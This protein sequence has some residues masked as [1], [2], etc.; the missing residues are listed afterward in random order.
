MNNF[1]YGSGSFGKWFIDEFGLPAYH[2]TCDQISDER[3]VSPCNPLWRNNTDHLHQIGNFRLNAVASNYGY[4]QVR[5]DEGCVKFLNDYRPEDN[6]LA[7]GIGYLTDENETL[8]TAYSKDNRELVRIFGSGYFK[9]RITNSKYCVEQVIYAPYGDDPLLISQVTVKNKSGNE[10]YVNWEEL[11]DCS[12]YQISFRSVLESILLQDIHKIPEIRRN[13]SKK[14][15]HNFEIIGNGKGI[16][17]TSKFSG[18]TDDEK[19]AWS[20]TKAVIEGISSGLFGGKIHSDVPGVSFYDYTPPSVFLVAL[21][22]PAAKL[23]IPDGTYMNLKRN[24]VLKPGE[25]KTIFNSFGYIPHGSNLSDIMELIDG[26]FSNPQSV[27]EE[28]CNSWKGRA[29]ILSVPDEPWVERELRWSNYYLKSNTTYDSFFGE[30]V[31]SQGSGYQYLMGIQAAPRDQ[32]QHCLPLIFTE[33]WLVKENI[34]YILKESLPDGELP[35][36]ITGNGMITP[37]PIKSSDFQLWII[38][39]VCEYV[40]A[41]RDISFLDEELKTYPVGGKEREPEKILSVLERMYKYLFRG[42]GY[43]RH[44]LLRLLKGDWNDLI[45]QGFVSSDQHD[46]VEAEAE[47]LLNS[48]M[49]SYV[50]RL[51]SGLYKYLG[52]VDKADQLAE[53]AADLRHA[54]QEQWNGKWFRRAW[55]PG[56][57]GWVGDNELWLEPQPWAVIGGCAESGHPAVLTENIDKLLREPSPIG[58]MLIDKPVAPE[59]GEMT[60]GGVWPSINGTLIWA[61]A[62][63]NPQKGWDEWKKNLLSTHAEIYPDIWYGIWSGPDYYNSVLARYPGHTFFDKSILDGGP[64]APALPNWTDFPVMCMHPHAWTIYSVLK[65]LGTEFT[66]SGIEFRPA[67]PKREYSFKSPLLEFNKMPDG[68]SG[69]YNPLEEGMWTVSITLPEEEHKIISKLVIN[70]GTEVEAVFREGRIVFTGESYHNKPL[71]WKLK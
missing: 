39:L 70:E 71:S 15:K 44:G 1:H 38:W 56:D 9:K 27:L 47:S 21:D 35:F 40:L 19:N 63:V 67:I 59:P 13:F 22:G 12:V 11:W 64:A 31:Q 6:C 41:T 57:G 37:T 8:T 2:Y 34:R 33:P 55:L 61:L 65:L 10:V 4:V 16:L 50:L 7:G 62:M 5:Q 29:A 23:E 60:N 25:S 69:C 53:E 49:A 36:G 45:V 43:G 42:T 20:N 18:W 26:K 17:D 58:S 51:Y 32:A 14:F 24:I 52:N 68:Y 3:A 66:A 54:V 48:A 46:A 30:H 28:T